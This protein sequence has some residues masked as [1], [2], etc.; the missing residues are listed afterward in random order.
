MQV[1]TCSGVGANGSLRTVRN[2]IG[3]IEHS[4]IEMPGIRGMWALRDSFS[5]AND[6]HLVLSFVS[7]TRLLS[8]SDE[9][10]L[11]EVELEAFLSDVQVGLLTPGAEPTLQIHMQMDIR[12]ACMSAL[13]LSSD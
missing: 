4:A 2:G 1:V 3:M 7:E 13:A 8:I 5:D 11:G 6:S 12:F 10:E 9:D